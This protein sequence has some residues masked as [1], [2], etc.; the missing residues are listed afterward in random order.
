[1]ICAL[2]YIYYIITILLNASSK[3]IVLTKINDAQNVLTFSYFTVRGLYFL[4]VI[5]AVAIYN[6]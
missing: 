2:F 1:M 4:A 5:F 6:I 3:T